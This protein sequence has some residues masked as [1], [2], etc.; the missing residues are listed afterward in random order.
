MTRGRHGTILNL[1]SQT[2]HCFK[3]EKYWKDS[4]RFYEFYCLGAKINTKYLINS[5]YLSEEKNWFW[6]LPRDKFFVWWLKNHEWQRKWSAALGR[7]GSV[8]TVN[9]SLKMVRAIY[10]CVFV[11]EQCNGLAYFCTS[12]YSNRN[13]LWHHRKLSLPAYLRFTPR[14][15]PVFLADFWGF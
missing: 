1:I 11:Y 12:S 5:K 6:L 9:G 15:F 13:L 14:Q 8:R 4:F 2:P 7:Y 3:R 10:F